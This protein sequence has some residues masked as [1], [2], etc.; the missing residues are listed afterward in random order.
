MHLQLLQSTGLKQVQEQPTRRSVLLDSV[1]LSQRLVD[2]RLNNRVTEIL[3]IHRAVEVHASVPRKSRTFCTPR[4][5]VLIVRV[6]L[7]LPIP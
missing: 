2:D 1:F 7:R 5:L 6:M 3:L 4:M